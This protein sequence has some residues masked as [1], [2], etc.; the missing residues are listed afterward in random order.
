LDELAAAAAER[1]I[2]FDA[3]IDGNPRRE[4]GW[5]DVTHV[6]TFANAA[7]TALE[8]FPSPELLRGLFYA[9]RFVHY[10]RNLDAP[11]NERWKVPAP[12][13]VDLE[14]GAFLD[15]LDR[16]TKELDTDRA[17]ALMRGY[18]AGRREPTL[19][20]EWM[21]RFAIADSAALDIW[22]A[23]T[24]KVTVAG[25]EE[26]AASESPRRDLT[27]VA[28]MRFLASPKA[29]RRVV[30]ASVLARDFVRKGR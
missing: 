15:E 23:H 7:R 22:L 27:L 28:A 9:A 11:P 21:T 29:E 18:I 6:L 17:V 8:M 20:R 14:T 5:L 12:A 24:I 30:Q 25:L 4:E 10:V 1:L 26:W 13:G 19:F 16:A 3:R 2:R